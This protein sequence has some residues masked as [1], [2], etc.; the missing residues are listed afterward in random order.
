MTDEDIAD[1][2]REIVSDLKEIAFEADG[3]IMVSVRLKDST[4]KRKNLGAKEV[5]F[6]QEIYTGKVMKFILVMRPE[7]PNPE[8]DVAE[9]DARNADDVFPFLIT[10]L[11]KWAQARY[12]AWVDC[13]RV[14]DF[15]KLLIT[16]EEVRRKD[17]QIDDLE[18]LKKN[19]LFGMF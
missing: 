11:N 19:P 9:V 7:D 10:E 15:E 3:P 18:E 1:L 17:A 6:L 16:A 5:C 2:Y 14:A 4:Y 8:F 13:E 12:S